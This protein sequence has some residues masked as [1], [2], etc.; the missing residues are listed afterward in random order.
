MTA[1]YVIGAKQESEL[2]GVVG[3]DTRP[4]PM[5]PGMAPARPSLYDALDI[6]AVNISEWGWLGSAGCQQ[7]QCSAVQCSAVQWCECE[8]EC[9]CGWCA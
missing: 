3:A 1:A 4:A 8:C 7:A 9:E 2:F 6:T 5:S